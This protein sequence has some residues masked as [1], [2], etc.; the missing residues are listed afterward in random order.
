M[1]RKGEEPNAQFAYAEPFAYYVPKALGGNKF[2]LYDLV[3]LN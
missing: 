3:E 2:L 1:N